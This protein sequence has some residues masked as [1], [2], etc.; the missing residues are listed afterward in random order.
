MNQTSSLSA[1]YAEVNGARLYY[2][3][4]G[5]GHPLVMIHA[6]I[7]DHR[8]WDGQF[9]SFAQH[10]KVVRYDTRG[11]GQSAMVDGPY[12]DRADL[13]A[14][15]QYL[16]IDRTYLMGCSMGGYMAIDFTLEHPAMVDAL[17]LVAADFAGFDFSGDPPPLWSEMAAAF[18]AGDFATAAELEA[19]MFFDGKGRTAD[20]VDPTMRKLLIEMNLLALPNEKQR[21]A[22]QLPPPDPP[23]ATRLGEIHVPLLYIYGDRDEDIFP[24]VADAL[25][26]QVRGTQ[27]VMM[28]DTAHLPSMEQPDKFNQIVG[29]F[30]AKV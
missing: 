5:D 14:L 1:G 13:L 26:A 16:G 12:S 3:M 8:M 20:Q 29:D 28:P 21:D 9:A 15:L 24:R 18:R 19:R 22:N 4:M 23:A 11:F 2:E 7:A 27:V 30:L 17:I 25:A 6:A 10:Y